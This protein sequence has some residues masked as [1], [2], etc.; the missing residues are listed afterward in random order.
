MR[1]IQKTFVPF[2]NFLNLKIFKVISAKI[3]EKDFP[4]SFKTDFPLFTDQ[5]K[6]ISLNPDI[7]SIE[8]L[9]FKQYQTIK[10]IILSYYLFIKCY[11]K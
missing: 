2:I 3:I 4:K 9:L 6:L 11:H 5:E 10:V 7:F 8:E 1:K